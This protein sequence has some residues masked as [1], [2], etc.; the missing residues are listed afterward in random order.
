MARCD[1]TCGCGG[2]CHGMA[3]DGSATANP[4]A[5]R[6]PSQPNQV[7]EPADARALDSRWRSV[8]VSPFLTRATL[9]GP[10][11][12][13]Y[14]AETLRAVDP[15]VART[16][17]LFGPRHSQVSGYTPS[18]ARNHAHWRRQFPPAAMNAVPF[19]T[20][21]PADSRLTPIRPSIPD[22]GSLI[23][24]RSHVMGIEF[25]R[26]FSGTPSPS[27]GRVGNLAVAPLGPADT[28]TAP[29]A[30]QLLTLGPTGPLVNALPR[31]IIGVDNCQPQAIELDVF[32]DEAGFKNALFKTPE[33]QRATTG[34]GK[35]WTVG[36]EAA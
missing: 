33:Y 3:P 6:S 34:S 36:H 25:S 1:G 21:V 11:P 8:G 23:E 14:G 10:T 15:V 9:T 31:Q 12:V 29:G 16:I 4:E 30:A 26:Q 17:P 13:P 27:L 2:T 22:V 24:H 19:S 32:F 35:G 18:S 20:A 28:Y 7:R 5:R